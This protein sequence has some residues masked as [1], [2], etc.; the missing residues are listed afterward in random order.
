[1]SVLTDAPE[2]A[3]DVVSFLGG[4]PDGSKDRPFPCKDSET[5]SIVLAALFLD[6]RFNLTFLG[7]GIAV[8]ELRPPLRKASGAGAGT[9]RAA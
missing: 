2:P 4:L 5:L 3:S 8:P 6:V 9:R 1:M 7:K